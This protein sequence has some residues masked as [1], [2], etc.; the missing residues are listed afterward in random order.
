MSGRTVALI[1]WYFLISSAVRAS[2]S[3]R[4]DDDGDDKGMG[5]PPPPPPGCLCD[6]DSKL[7]TNA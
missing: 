6:H 2:L 5:V 1:S 4:T 7:W 3:V